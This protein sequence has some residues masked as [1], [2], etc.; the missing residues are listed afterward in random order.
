MDKKKHHN[1]KTKI[2][3]KNRCQ[4][5]ELKSEPLAPQS[6]PCQQSHFSII[7]EHARIIILGSFLSIIVL[8]SGVNSSGQ[9]IQA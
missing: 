4:S 9:M 6:T 8:K 3:H 7:F 1:N 5:R 2:K